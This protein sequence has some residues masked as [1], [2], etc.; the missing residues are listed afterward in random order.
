MAKAKKKGT[1]F[2]LV[3]NLIALVGMAAFIFVLWL[4]FQKTETDIATGG[5]SAGSSGG[6]AAPLALSSVSPGALPVSGGSVTLHGAGFDKGTRV[7]F[8]GGDLDYGRTPGFR[9]TLGG[10]FVKLGSSAKVLGAVSRLFAPEQS[11]AHLRP[12]GDV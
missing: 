5:G 11:A 8:G 4:F 10:W 7:L 6:P 1:G 3:V 9:L 2:P 12:A